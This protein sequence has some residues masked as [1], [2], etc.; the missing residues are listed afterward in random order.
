[1]FNA[2]VWNLYLAG[3][4][5]DVVRKFE[6]FYRKG[7]TK[8]YIGLIRRLHGEYQ[9]EAASLA[10]ET[11]Q[12]QD[13]AS[14]IG[15]ASL[16]TLY[17]D[18]C[19]DCQADPK[20]LFQ[21]FSAGLSFYTTCLALAKPDLFIPYY[22]QYSYNV[23][24]AMADEFGLI[25]P[26]IPNKSDYYGRFI[27]YE[28]ICGVLQEFR[29]ANG[30]SVPELCAF[31]YDFGPK[32]VGGM[33]CFLIPEERL[34]EPGSAFLIGSARTDLFFTE[35]PAA[36]IP[37]QCSP[38]TKAGDMIVMYLTS[39][40]C[41]AGYVWRSC[42]VGFIDPFFFY[43]RC[44]YICHP[45][46]IRPVTLEQMRHDRI[47]RAMPIVKKNMQ[48]V[49]GVE[50]R[51]LQYNRIVTLGKR[52]ALRIEYDEA[53]EADGC[54][55]ERDVED[56]IIKPLLARL[57]YEKEDYVQQ[58]EL[59][60][61]NQNRG[62]IPDFVLLPDRKGL[63]HRGFAVVE[64]KRSI[65]QLPQLE[66]ALS[67]VRS[68]AK[69]LSAHYAAIISREKLWIYAAADDYEKAVLETRLRDMTDDDFFEIRKLIGKK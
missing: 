45:I 64:A 61:G 15:T 29:E 3:G 6:A 16:E 69:L 56:K 19:H 63:H 8:D 47:L 18:M 4:G 13:A 33:S 21:E 10:M 39:P 34:P 59:R 41:A 38:D 54:S 62:L 20:S 36:V 35:D 17:E 55:T 57:G 53:V 1:M 67:Q 40:D 51:P 48:G 25:L 52:E 26:A 44:T 9:P 22:F 58:L 12:L 68:Y 27:H 28:K 43:Y 24:T 65:T 2:Y 23:L 66:D 5:A 11:E 37:W 7:I 42:S 49:N 31:L 60:F 50:L 32:C 46:K 30:L 14:Q